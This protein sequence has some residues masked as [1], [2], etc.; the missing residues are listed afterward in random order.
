MTGRE[1]NEELCNNAIQTINAIFRDVSGLNMTEREQIEELY[2]N[3]M[4]KRIPFRCQT[5]ARSF[6]ELYKQ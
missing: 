6:S 4:L 5:E 2:A 3:A 1:W